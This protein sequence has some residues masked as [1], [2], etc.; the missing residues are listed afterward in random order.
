MPKKIRKC[1]MC[2]G[3]RTSGFVTFG[4]YVKGAGV[5]CV[6]NSRWLN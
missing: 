1:P 6:A 3:E 2:K 4:V 5:K